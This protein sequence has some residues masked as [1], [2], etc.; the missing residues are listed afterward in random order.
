M[1][2]SSNL[3]KT[4]VTLLTGFLGAGKT[5]TMS[6][7]AHHYKSKGLNVALVTN[8]QAVNLVDTNSLRSQGLTVEEVAGACFCCKFDELVDKVGNVFNRLVLFD[9]KCIHAATE[10]YG[11]NISDSR[12]FQLF[13]FDIK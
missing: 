2:L 11:T 9:A 7:L 6:K 5:T 13:F 12:F 1:V 8:D 4:P 3:W 10:Y